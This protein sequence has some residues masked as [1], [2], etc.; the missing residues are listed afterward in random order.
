P[1]FRSRAVLDVGGHLLREPEAGDLDAV[2]LLLPGHDLCRGQESA[3]GRGGDDLEVRVGL[4]ETLSLGRA[5]LGVVIAVD[6]VDELEALVLVPGPGWLHAVD[7]R[8]LV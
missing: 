6:G 8:V 4:Q 2:P 5:L 3:P 1:E 7:T